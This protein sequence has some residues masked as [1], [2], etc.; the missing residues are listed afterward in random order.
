MPGVAPLASSGVLERLVLKA[1]RRKPNAAS[2]RK[3]E[4][5]IRGDEVG[6]RPPLPH[7]PV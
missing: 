7:M 3:Q 1:L 5:A 6:H 4:L 2:V